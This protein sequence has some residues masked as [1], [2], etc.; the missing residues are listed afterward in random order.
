MGSS[1]RIFVPDV[2][3]AYN[4]LNSPMI[5]PGQQVYLDVQMDGMPLFISFGQVVFY[6]I[7]NEIGS[8]VC[9]DVVAYAADRDVETNFCAKVRTGF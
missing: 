9:A 1:L 2:L 3:V 5:H 6:D 8:Q 7:G 4:N